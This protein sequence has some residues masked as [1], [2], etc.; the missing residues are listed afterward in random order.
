[1]LIGVLAE[2]ITNGLGIIGLL[3]TFIIGLIG[4]ILLF[5]GV[6]FGLIRMGFNGDFFGF[7][8]Y[9]CRKLAV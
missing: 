6:I 1:M 2:C 3:P 8:Y 9:D 7:I 5:I 4:D